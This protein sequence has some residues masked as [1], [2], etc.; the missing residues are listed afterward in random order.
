MNNIPHLNE[1]NNFFKNAFSLKTVIE[2]INLDPLLRAI[3]CFRKF[4]V[5]TVLKNFISYANISQFCLQFFLRYWNNGLLSSEV[6]LT[7]CWEVFSWNLV[8]HPSSDR[9]ASKIP[10]GVDSLLHQPAFTPSIPI[11]SIKTEIES[12]DQ[13]ILT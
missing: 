6:S 3:S 11:G 8:D 2:W 12:L 7:P 10:Y 4:H 13:L 9:V 5:L 1:K